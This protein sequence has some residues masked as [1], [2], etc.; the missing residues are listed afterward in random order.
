MSDRI[1]SDSQVD[2]EALAFDTFYCSSG[3]DGFSETSSDSGSRVDSDLGD[4]YVR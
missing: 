3:C 1:E 4:Q 2:V